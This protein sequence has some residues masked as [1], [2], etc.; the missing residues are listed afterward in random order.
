MLLPHCTVDLMGKLV[1]LYSSIGAVV[2]LHFNS[3]FTLVL[4][5]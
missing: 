1:Y 3:V 2:L 4:C 5:Y